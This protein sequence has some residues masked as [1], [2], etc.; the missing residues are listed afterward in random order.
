MATEIAARRAAANCEVFSP[1]PSG[2]GGVFYAGTPAVLDNYHGVVSQCGDGKGGDWKHA[3]APEDVVGA[4]DLRCVQLGYEGKMY[5]IIDV[6]DP[7]NQLAVVTNLDGT[8]AVELTEFDEGGGKTVRRLTL[9][10][11]EC[12]LETVQGGMGGGRQEAG[13]DGVLKGDSVAKVSKSQRPEDVKK[14]RAV[15]DD[16]AKNHG[17]AIIQAKQAA[18]IRMILGKGKRF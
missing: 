2:R 11:N 14:C 9:G 17:W 6:G 8:G 18:G 12:T 13:E 4:T 5:D 7:K 16:V 3:N 1:Y 15:R 10:V